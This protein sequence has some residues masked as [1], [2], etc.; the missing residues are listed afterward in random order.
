MSQTKK[1]SIGMIVKNE[2]KYLR[3]C[4]TAL[5]PLLKQVDSELIIVDT[6]STDSTLSIAKE[7]TAL[8]YSFDWCDDFAAAR[9]ET[10]RHAKG[11]WYMFLDADEIFGELTSLIEFFNSGEYLKFNS[12]SHMMDNIVGD[13]ADAIVE[14]RLLRLAKRRKELCFKGAIH[15]VLNS[16]L[17]IKMLS[18][19]STHYGYDFMG[20]PEK[21]QRKHQRNIVPLLKEYEENPKDLRTLA[22]IVKE[23]HLHKNLP[24]VEE[25][26]DIM[27]ELVKKQPDNDYALFMLYRRTVVNFEMQKFQTCLQCA[28]EYF[29][30]KKTEV[31]SDIDIYALC[32]RAHVSLAHWDE[33]I[34][35]LK[36][37]LELYD[38]FGKGELDDSDLLYNELMFIK[39]RFREN[40]RSL[41][42]R[43]YEE[44]KDYDNALLWLEPIKCYDAKTVAQYITLAQKKGND[45]L[46][47]PLYFSL[48]DLSEKEQPDTFIAAFE[49]CVF[50]NELSPEAFKKFADCENDDPYVKLQALRY[51][52]MANDEEQLCRLTE[53]FCSS[54]TDW[55]DTYSD[56]V[57]IAIKH[58]IS[59]APLLKAIDIE[60]FGGLIRAIEARH[61][62]IYV[63][64]LDTN[65]KALME[66]TSTR[67]LYWSTCLLEHMLLSEYD[68]SEE[69]YMALFTEYTGRVVNIANALYRPEIFDS[70]LIELLPGV[71]R[72]GHF[73][74]EAYDADERGNKLQY[75]ANIRQALKN[76]PV[77]KKP[78]ELLLTQIQREQEKT[79][80]AQA[81]FAAQAVLIKQKIDQLIAAGELGA[82]REI[83]PALDQLLPEDPDVQRYKDE[84]SL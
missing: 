65:S 84:C 58:N 40:T 62:D 49:L 73:M 15:E 76:Y 5:M 18:A 42:A 17:P 53:W 63:S 61:S 7:F 71:Y 64:I 60:W 12:A 70:D 4:L 79:D 31:V 1:L 26:L 82:V 27:Y 48:C 38:S 25:Y 16:L 47:A 20:D 54:F 52:D 32:G 50:K 69:H 22:H 46:L 41:I 55:N 36:K 24:K 30:S 74:G 8:V 19:R 44:L 59:M 77:M 57:Y 83:L 67:E 72:F 39:N 51:F 80:A 68:F 33:A 75:M 43:V 37:S 9:N 66:G 45:D 29:N 11:E 3:S 14:L 23:Y 81:E 2:E 78:I 34:K 21:E 56:V 28:E 35:A 6:G 10:L 13:N